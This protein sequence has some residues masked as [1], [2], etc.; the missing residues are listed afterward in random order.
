[1]ILLG[2]PG[3]GKGTQAVGLAEDL[4]IARISSGDLFREHQQKETELGLLARRYMERGELVPDDVTIKMVVEW[5]NGNGPR[6]GFLLDGF[7]RTLAQAQALDRE[8]AAA[9]GVNKVI[10]MTVSHAELIRR[11][12]GRLLCRDCQTPHQAESPSHGEAGKCGR[13]GGG[14]YQREDDK[15]EAVR[16]RIEVYFAETE[17]L[18]DYYRQAGKLQEVDGEG[19]IED[20]GRAMAA[21]VG[22]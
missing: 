1:M 17:P 11:L 20:V 7:P 14:L 9:G 16:K 6:D 3:A 18:V 15:P 13:C 19:S 4:G 21:A 12:T 2:P 5:I 22:R 8:I 10:H